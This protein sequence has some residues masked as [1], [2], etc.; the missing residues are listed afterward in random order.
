VLGC[1]ACGLSPFCGRCAPAQQQV[2]GGWFVGVGVGL[3]MLCRTVVRVC[4][5][6]AHTSQA[7]E[8]IGACQ[9]TR[10]LLSGA[11]LDGLHDDVVW[12]RGGSLFNSATRKGAREAGEIPGAV[13]CSR[14]LHRID[15]NQYFCVQIHFVSDDRIVTPCSPG[16]NHIQNE[17]L[18]NAQYERPSPSSA[19]SLCPNARKHCEAAVT[20]RQAS[21]APRR[22]RSDYRH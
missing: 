13:Y 7:R 15:R 16:G 5:R 6:L 22:P 14:T 17:Q 4:F 10:G 1:R 18:N 3:A 19:P 9:C 12:K 8:P 21:H 20:E 2:C 11:V